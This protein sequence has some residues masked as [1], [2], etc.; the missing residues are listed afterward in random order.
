MLNYDIIPLSLYINAVMPTITHS[1]ISN[2]L[3][4]AITNISVNIFF[5]EHTCRL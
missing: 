2:N 3:K 4:N 1:N 5:G